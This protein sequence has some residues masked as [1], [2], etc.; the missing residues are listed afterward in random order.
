[1][2]RTT[3]PRKQATG[4][5]ARPLTKNDWPVI[6]KLFGANGACGG[7][8][9]MYWRLPRGGKLWEDSK[10]AKNK[11]S[12]K[13]LLTQGKVHGCLAFEGD[14][15]VGWC[16]VGP[17][18]DFPR[19]QRTRALATEWNVTTWS[20]VCFYIRTPWRRRG[21]AST[22]LKQAVA[23][24][25]TGGATELEGYPVRA[26][27]ADSDIPAA[28]AW[29]GVEPLFARER[30]VTITPPGQSRDVYRRSFRQPRAKSR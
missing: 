19:L 16:C 12:F 23:V 4:I 1:M 25:K 28:F 18:G 6:D 17:R 14:E 10:G 21:V 5:T 20:V 3:K 26:K 15:P 22:L 8:W 9:C 11:R 2:A 24:A 13:R 7:C 30:F 27:S 29:T